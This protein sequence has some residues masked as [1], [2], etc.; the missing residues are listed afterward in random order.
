[1]RFI[2]V[3]LLRWLD[4][5]EMALTKLE[6][7]HVSLT[8]ASWPWGTVPDA[9]EWASAEEGDAMEA[10]TLWNKL[11]VGAVVCLLAAF[12]LSTMPALL[13]PAA[14]DQVSGVRDDDLRE[15]AAVSD[16]DDDDDDDTHDGD[17][18][19]GATGGGSNSGS[20]SIGSRSGGTATGSTRG[21]GQSKSVSNSS[22]RSKNTAT[23]TTRGTGQSRSVSNSS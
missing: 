6:R 5:H 16:D 8:F 12:V 21:T 17:T 4:P 11:G 9:G 3:R 18:D 19:D 10:T 2:G 7:S 13:A 15:I 23:G 1:M 14:A 22:D 20:R